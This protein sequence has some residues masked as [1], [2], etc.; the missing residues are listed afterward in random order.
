MSNKKIKLCRIFVF[1][2]KPV[3]LNLNIST[4]LP[5]IRILN[6]F[7]QDHYVWSSHTCARRVPSL[8]TS[9]TFCNITI[10]CSLIP[11]ENIRCSITSVSLIERLA[12]LTCINY[13]PN[14]YWRML[15][16]P[17][18][19]SSNLHFSVLQILLEYF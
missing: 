11:K 1:F 13:M 8:F 14:L 3:M 12:Q 18:L 19:K 16:A 15:K 4:I 17:P 2:C 5:N 6:I 10:S 9:F 7:L